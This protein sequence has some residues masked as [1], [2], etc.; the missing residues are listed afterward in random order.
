MK[1]A[2]FEAIHALVGQE[3]PPS[4]WITVDQDRINGFAAIT[5]D[6]QFIHVDPERAKTTP[7][8]GTVAHGLL[9]LSLLPAMQEQVVPVPAEAKMVVNYGFNKVRFAAPVRS[10]KRVRGSFRIADFSQTQPGRWQQLAEVKVE[11]EGEA[12][13]ALT[14]EWIGICFV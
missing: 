12:K 13:P 3:L 5:G 8:G 4:D 14:A 2:T 10:G 11:I 6:H 9:T 7:F 1:T